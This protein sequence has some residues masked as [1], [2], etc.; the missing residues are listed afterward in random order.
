MNITCKQA[1]LYRAIHAL[2][3]IAKKHL[4]LPILEYILFHIKDGI[5]T[6]TATNLDISLQTTLSAKVEGEGE[7]ALPART[8]VEYVSNIPSESVIC[9]EMQKTS[10]LFSVG[11]HTATI[12]GLDAQDFPLIPE[13]ESVYLA[14]GFDAQKLKSAFSKS[15]I[16]VNQTNIRIEFTGVNMNINNKTAVFASTDSFRLMEVQT[17]I[18]P[19]EGYDAESFEGV[20]FPHQTVSELLK[21]ITSEIEQVEMRFEEGQVFIRIN[22]EY[23][24]VSRLVNGKFP[25]YRQIIPNESTLEIQIQKEVLLQAMRISGVFLQAGAQEVGIRTDVEGKKLSIVTKNQSKG[26]SNSEVTAELKGEDIEVTLNPRYVID[27]LGAYDADRIYIVCKDAYAPAI[28]RGINKKGEVI[29]NEEYILMP[30]K[31]T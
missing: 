26:E 7:V 9:I 2:S 19:L 15:L 25:D 23:S 5:V 14:L 13:P 29:E 3:R 22:S 1:R 24:M 12:Q 20:I 21:L 27:I 4:S 30:I 28:F 17:P 6:L 18:Q 11:A 31:K 16:C 10:A 8:L